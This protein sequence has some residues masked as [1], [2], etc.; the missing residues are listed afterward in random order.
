MHRSRKQL[1]YLFI[2]LFVLC[3]VQIALSLVSLRLL[4]HPDSSDLCGTKHRSSTVEI[5]RPQFFPSDCVY[6]VSEWNRRT[7]ALF[8]FSSFKCQFIGAHHVGKPL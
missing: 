2:E 5:E 6:R 3:L 8:S 4:G 7:C 1:P